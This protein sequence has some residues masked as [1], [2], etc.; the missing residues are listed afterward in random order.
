MGKI[1]QYPKAKLIVSIFTNKKELLKQSINK[2]S[3]TFG[4]IDLES[5]LLSFNYTSYYEKE[6]GLEL[7]RKIISFQKLIDPERL[8]EIKIYTNNLEESLS[9]AE[10][11]KR[12][13]N[14]D[15]GYLTSAKLILATTK[16]RS[17]RVYLGQGIF[18]E[19]TL[20]YNSGK[21][22]PW[23]WTYKSY[24]S[25]EHLYFLS[26]VRKIYLQQLKEIGVAKQN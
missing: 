22:E 19:V 26:E 13:I 17:H 16:D 20:K 10:Q 2:L 14:I 5:E 15:P 4:K 18:G 8:A 11:G 12:K 25:E 24:Q 3:D 6:F 21:F 9:G 1:K 23:N 7:K